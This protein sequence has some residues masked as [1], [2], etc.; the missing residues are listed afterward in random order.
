MPLELRNRP[1]QLELVENPPSTV[2]V[3]VRGASSLLSQLSPSDVVAELDLALARPG[4]RYY[5]VTRAEVRAPFG[6]DVVDVTPGTISLR[7]EPSLTRRVPVVP[8]IDGE[9][10]PGRRQRRGERHS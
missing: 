7:F 4:R 9:P 2:E 8:M 6:I 10:V 3:R 1:P 5:P